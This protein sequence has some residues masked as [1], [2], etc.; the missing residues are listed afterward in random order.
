MSGWDHAGGQLLKQFV[1]V[2]LLISSL[3]AGA[4]P[5][6][7]GQGPAMGQGQGDAGLPDF[8]GFNL[9]DS[10]ARLPPDRT[11]LGTL[12]DIR[13]ASIDEITARTRTALQSVNESS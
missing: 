8:S 12:C 7:L 11:R 4:A 13:R 6:V 9:V 10:F 1:L 2:T 3:L 5:P